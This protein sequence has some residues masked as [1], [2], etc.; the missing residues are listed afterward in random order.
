MTTRS[1]SPG[2]AAGA[3]LLSIVWM[4]AC[5]DPTAPEGVSPDVPEP[6]HVTASHG[7][8]AHYAVRLLLGP[9]SDRRSCTGVV[10]T[11]HW[12]MTAAHC[13]RGLPVSSNATTVRRGDIA[14]STSAEVFNGLASYYTHP[15]YSGRDSDMGDDFALILLYGGGMSAY[16]SARIMG[17]SSYG[18]LVPGEIGYAW[19]AGYGHGTGSGGSS[20]CSNGLGVKR[21][22]NFKVYL[23][24]RGYGFDSP[25]THW[26][27]GSPFINQMKLRFGHHRPCDGDSGAPIYFTYPIRAYGFEFEGDVVAGLWAGT[28]DIPVIE[29]LHKGPSIRR[30][31]QWIIDKTIQK[32]PRI[33]CTPGYSDVGPD[34]WT[35]SEKPPYTWVNGAGERGAAPPRPPA[36]DGT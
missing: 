36:R 20:S 13:V 22:G 6:Q 16:T 23:N 26:S 17:E 24:S 34:Y 21:T 2:K 33:Y 1:C 7:G 10:L 25:G 5:D 12:V 14:T 9:S 28:V 8:S 4:G 35:C 18:Y 11:R 3:V 29:Q 15:E 30:R 31:L 32:T 27:P 19:I